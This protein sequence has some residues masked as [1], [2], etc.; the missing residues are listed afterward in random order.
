MTIVAKY[1]STCPCCSKPIAVGDKIEWSKG[2]KARHVACKSASA[3]A[4]PAKYQRLRAVGNGPY[5]HV[6]R[7][8]RASTGMVLC[9]ACGEENPPGKRCWEC[10]C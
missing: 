2:Q 4:A 9:P 3:P 6:S 8:P 10:G 7:A 1:P 5:R